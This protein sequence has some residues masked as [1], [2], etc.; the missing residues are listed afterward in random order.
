M[1]DPNQT[2]V[3]IHSLSLLKHD[4]KNQDKRHLFIILSKF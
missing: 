1:V 2:H 3:I 4:M